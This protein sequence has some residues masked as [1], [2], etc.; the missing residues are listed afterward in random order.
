MFQL[1]A[2]TCICF[3]F[4]KETY[5]PRIL[6]KIAARKRKQT[7]DSRYHSTFYK[8][9]SRG[10]LLRTALVRPTKMLIRSPIVA[11]LALYTSIINAYCTILFAT[12]GTVYETSYGFTVGQGGLAYFGLT[13]GFLIGQVTI[14]IFSDRYLKYM[15]AKREDGAMK[16]EYRLPP[17]ILGSILLPTGF[18]W[19]GWATQAHTHWIVPVLGTSLVGIAAMFSYLPVQLYLVDTYTVFAASAIASN[20]VVRSVCAALIPLGTDPLYARLG[21]GWGN[22]VL[23]FIALGFVPVAVLLVMF[24]ERL[25]TNVRFQPKL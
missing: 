19:Y 21:Y 14:G 17:L 7:G 20:S 11:L 3:L 1:G 4:L 24:G 15:K 18:L 16:P 2:L 10:Q 23:A 5:G 6:E 12:I 8:A 25:R 13:A 22:S 9:Q